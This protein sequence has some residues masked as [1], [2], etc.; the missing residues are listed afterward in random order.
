MRI[1]NHHRRAAAVT[2]GL[3]V[4]LAG[5]AAAERAN[6]QEACRLIH[7]CAEASLHRSAGD[8]KGAVRWQTQCEPKCR[9][10]MQQQQHHPRTPPPASNPPRPAPRPAV[11]SHTTDSVNRAPFNPRASTPPQGTPPQPPPAW[12]PLG[13]TYPAPPPAPLPVSLISI[14]TGGSPA[15]SPPASPAPAAPSAPAASPTD[16]AS[17]APADVAAPS[18]APAP[19]ATAAL[20]GAANT[21]APSSSS[22]PAPAS[23]DAAQPSSGG[24]SASAAAAP[25][26]DDPRVWL[27]ALPSVASAKLAVRGADPADTA[28]RQQAALGTLWELVRSFNSG[29]NRVR[30]AGARYLEYYNEYKAASPTPLESNRYYL[31]PS[32]RTKV[33]TDLLSKEV[34]RAYEATPSYQHARDLAAQNGGDPGVK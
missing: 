1:G 27:A 20:A 10:L 28:L 17:P 18:L 24:T 15:P 2:L 26:S 9:A 5:V 30:S 3:C 22:A 31:L 7:E 25:S 32:F 4:A 16:P 12:N 6:A 34:A 19:S 8:P 13:S 14:L 23:S 29:A 21:T 33:I 11:N